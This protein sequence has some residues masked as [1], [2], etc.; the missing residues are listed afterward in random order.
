ME[1]NIENFFEEPQLPR[2]S[3]PLQEKYKSLHTSKPSC[4]VVSFI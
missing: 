4:N 3:S 1:K 2:A